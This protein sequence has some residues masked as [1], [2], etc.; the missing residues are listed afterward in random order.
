VD[1]ISG[2]KALTRWMSCFLNRGKKPPS[3]TLNDA[4]DE[5]KGGVPELVSLFSPGGM[6]FSPEIQSQ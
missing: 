5:L 3:H 1:P 4:I 6:K 2:Y